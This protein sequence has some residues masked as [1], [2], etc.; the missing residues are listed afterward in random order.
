MGSSISKEEAKSVVPNES[1]KS[2]RNVLENLAKDIKRKASNNAKRHENVLKANLRQA[3]FRHEFSAYRPNYGNPCELDYRFHTNV[4]NRGASE[5]DPCY[6]R[7]PKNNSK[8]KGAVCTN[9]KIK[10]N[11][12][13]INDTG[14]CAPYRRRNI[15]DY[16]LEHIH[17]GN[18]LT[19][20]DLLGNVLVMAKNEGASI[21]NSNAHN[22]VLNV[23]TVLAR[24][25]ADIGD[26]LRGKDLYLG[27]NESEK[28][29]KEELQGN[30]EK[31]FTKI[32]KNDK[33]LN[34]LSNG[35]VREAWWALNR[36]DVW[37]AL[38]CSAPHNAQYVKYVPG[39]TTAVSSNKCGHNDMNVPTNLDYVPQF[40]R[41]FEEWAEEF[42]RI[43]KIKL[44]NVEKACRDDSKNLYCS[45]NGYDCTKTI[46]NENIL[47]DDPKCNSCLA[48]CSLYDI[49]LRNQRNEFEKQKEIYTKEIQIYLSNK[50]KSSSSI[51]NEYYKDFY[52]ELKKNEYETGNKFLLLLNEGKFCNEKLTGKRS[53]DFSNDVDNIFSH[54]KHCKVCPHCG[55]D[56]SN[57][58]CKDRPNK[59]NCGKN[60]IYDPPSDVKPTKITV[61]YSSNEKR[62]ITE[63]LKDFCTK[64]NKENE[65][66]YQKWQCYYVSSENNGCK[67]VKNSGNITDEEKITSFDEFFDFWVRKFLID[68]IKWENE[69]KTC[70][71]NTTN[72]D[73]NNECNKN[74]ICFYNWVKQKEQE[75]T[76]M[77]DLFTNKHDIPKQYYLNINYLFDSFYFQ[78]MYEL[79]NEEAKWKE[80]IQNLR[81]K[82]NSSKENKGTTDSESA[83]KVLFDHLKETATICK[84]NNTNEA[85]DSNMDHEI[86]PCAKNTTT[87]SGGGGK[88]V[89]VKQIAQYYKRKAHAQLEERGSRS[90]LKGDASQGHYA[91]GG[92]REH[93]KDICKIT[94]IHSNADG[95]KS[96]NPC[97]GKNT[98]RFYTGKDWTYANEKNTTTYSDVYLPQRREHMCTSNLEHLDIRSKGLSNSS[99]ASNS[100]LGDVLLAA[101]FEAENIKKLYQQNNSKNGVIDQ[102]DKETVCRAMKYSFAD[103]GDIIR[104]KDM[105]DKDKGS[106]D[107]E[108]RLVP[109]FKKIKEQLLNSSIKEKYNKDSDNDGNKYINLRKDWWEANRD[110]VWKAMKCPNN[111]ITCGSSDH[112]PLDDYIPQR[113]RWMTEWAEWYCKMQSQEYDKLKQDCQGC[114]GNGKSLPC[115]QGTVQCTK[116]KAACDAYK[117]EIEKWEKQWKEM[118]NK[119]ANLYKEATEGGTASDRKDKDV[120]D[121]LKQLKEAN[122]ASGNTTYSTAAGYIHQE[123]K[124]IDC[125]IQT[126][127]C[128]KRNGD[129]P[130]NGEEKVDNEKY[131]FE[132]LPSEYQ[133]ACN[134]NENVTPRPPA[135]SNV[136]NTVK[137]HIGNN[138]GTQEIDNCK[139]KKDYPPWKNDKSLVDEDGV[140]MPP[141]RQ[142]LCVIN[143]QHFKENTSDGLRKAFI[144]C[145]AA[146]TFLL[147]HKYKKDKND[148]SNN[149]DNTLKSGTIPEEFK[150]QMFYTF[151]DFR[152]L[153]LGTD[154]SASNEPVKTVKDKIKN[155]FNTN[156]G[157]VKG[158]DKE[159]RESFW[160]EHKED[161]WEGMLCALSYDT[162]KQTMDKEVHT[163]LNSNYNYHTI[164]KDLED[165]VNRPQFL[166][167]FTEWSDEFCQ[168]YKVEKAKLFD[169]CNKVDCSKE[170]E[171]NRKKKQ[172]CAEECKAY[173]KWL[174][175]WNDK[176]K[177]QSAKF[178]NDKTNNKYKHDLA[179]KEADT[180][181]SARDYLKT[182]LQ[183]L[184]VKNGDCKCM[185]HKS[186]QSP[187]NTDM[188]A[189]LDDEPDEVK[190]RCKC[191]PPPPPKPKPTRE[192]LGRSLG[193][194]SKE[195]EEEEEEEDSEDDEPGEDTNGATEAPV[196]TKKDVDVCNTV[197]SALDDMGSLTQACQ[198]KYEKGREKFPNW[199]CVTPS[200]DKTATGSSGAI[201]VP[202]RRRKLYVGELTKWAEEATKS[203]SQNGESSGE[204][205]TQGSSNTTVNVDVDLVKAFVESAAVE[206][207]FLWH[208]YKVENTKTQGVG[209]PLLQTI[210]G[211]SGDDN[212]P[213]SK[214]EKGEI[215]P[216]FLRLMFYTLGDYR[217]ICIGGDRDIVG[218]TIVSNTSNNEAS[219]GQV[220]RKTI[221]DVIKQTLEKSGSK[222]GNSSPPIVKTPSQ[223]GDKRKKWWDQNA[224]HIWNGMICALT[225][226][227]NGEKKI[228]KDNEVYKKLWDEANKKPQKHQY[229]YK[230]V[231]LEEN[232]GAKSTG[233]STQ[234]SASSGD[235]PTLNTPKL[236][237]FVLR[238]PYFRYLE[239][240]GET[241][242]RER[243]KRLAQIYK[244]CRGKNA[245]GDPTY[246]SGDGYHCTEDAKYRN[247]KFVDLNCRGCGEQCMK[248]KKWIDMKFKEYQNQKSKYQEELQKLLKDNSNGGGDNKEFCQQIKEKSTSAK[249]LKELKHCK[250]DQGGEE[251]GNELDF[252]HPEKTFSPSTYC[253][254]CPVYGVTCNS[255]SGC[256]EN[257]EK[258]Q[259]NGKRVSTDI[260]IL[261][262]DGA[263]DG[264]TDG[265]TKDIDEKLK[266]C[267]KKYS[268]FKG[269]SKQEWKCQKIN[270]VDQCKLTNHV[271][272]TYFDKDIVFNEF[273]QRWLRYFIYDYNKLKHKIHPCIKKEKQDKTEHKC[274]K[275]CNNKCDCVDK[276]LKQKKQE[277]ENVKSHYNKYPR[278]NDDSVG[279][280]VKSYFDLL[281]FDS[282]IKKIKGKHE[283]FNRFEDSK[284]CNDTENSKSGK[285]NDVIECL[286]ENLGKKISECTSQASGSE[287]CTQ[288]T[289]DPPTLEDEDLLLE[290]EENQVK[291][292]EI[293]ENVLKT[294]QPE[295]GEKGDCGETDEKK[296]PKAEGE[297][298]GA[299]GPSG[300]A[301]PEPP[302]D[303]PPPSTPR[304]QPLP[305]DNTSDILKTTIPFG[306]ALA[307]TSIALLFLKKKP[308][309][310]VDLIRVLDIH[311]GDYGTPTPKSKNRY[312]PYRSGTYKGKTYIYMEGDSS[313]DE[314]YA[315]LS[316]TTDVT[317]SESEYE[318]LDINDIY[319]P[320]APKYKTLIEVV[321]EPSKSDGTP[322]SKGEP[323]RDDTPRATTPL[324]D[325]EWNELKHDFISQYIQSES[326][327]VPQYDVLKELPMN[328]GGNVLDDGINEKPFITSIHDRDLYTGEEISYNINMS[329]NSMDDPKHVSNNVYSGIDLINDTLSGNKNIDI[330][331]EVLKRKENELFGTNYKKNTS[332]NSVAKNTN[333]DPIMNQLDLLHKWLD[334]HRDMCKKWN[335]KEELLDKLNEQW[336]KDNDVGGDIST[337]N[338]NKTLNTDVSIQIDIDETKGKKE[339]SNMNT[340][341]DDIEDDIYYDVNDENP[342]VNDIPMDHNRVDVPKKVHVEM[343]ILNNTSNGSLEQEFPISDVW[344]I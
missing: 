41:W 48:K 257:K 277:W 272:A 337:S 250:N 226:K 49:W 215:P 342:S 210:D 245:N 117:K 332:N 88:H 199:K 107:M 278:T 33:T 85:C 177:I 164:K 167:W 216:D 144:Q 243:A 104:G 318:E 55:V 158:S 61:L 71:N 194:R 313:G 127:F 309:S 29:K 221:S 22:G 197:K 264:S 124:Y 205:Q 46:R 106:T 304:P 152:D 113:L 273:F 292:P 8:L 65:K 265:T 21:V 217:D 66:N 201:C 125:K 178:D 300:R 11:E 239:E 38:T 130:T 319:A 204:A 155:V 327:D 295:T 185:E 241:F 315:F 297:E 181:S 59:G 248:Y 84:D 255:S 331:D 120:V 24:S 159:K 133:E 132:K 163:K 312:I 44:E 37:K 307:L 141:R 5:R 310:P 172:A 291:P 86:N 196:E 214:L 252:E 259:K 231:K 58:T 269:L 95:S 131:A 122:K 91:R 143:L 325:E 192:G 119:Y 206:T 81:T 224:K 25:F 274:I 142:K 343:K 227:D 333:S 322:L 137:E 157:L 115:E 207:F 70:I 10:G 16:N 153:C 232:S 32:I 222:P 299:A 287:Q 341:L 193:P 261:I 138:N 168:K 30:L 136:C 238:P 77:M 288:T 184:C 180:A 42:C 335:T 57:G 233:S 170:D 258:V 52:E 19:T 12:N 186:K 116:C 235:T 293:C 96:K 118:E 62:G 39:N 336:N 171:D 47:S 135:L 317:S 40:L 280:R 18:V 237:D 80:Y 220:T 87:T 266:E 53:I 219:S 34:N 160:N 23:C 209:S 101:K 128:K 67:M 114:V 289:T 165:F 149:L 45:H 28:K 93:F 275:E 102:N 15:C 326:L 242:C 148:N 208:K 147:W 43:R 330:Y 64:S 176:Y 36:K 212:N 166:R 251:K 112:T 268:L 188:P 82:I 263:T 90:A 254:A 253:K 249:F 14:A 60:L 3:K 311:K 260:P 229:E 51:N 213:Q 27:N 146:E 276:W 305:S 314:K 329:T 50:K 98:E 298:S 200:G 94:Q 26:I 340:I 72:A 267:S 156:N 190:G 139:P 7:Q 306:I 129:K 262:N 4:W 247:H 110:Q 279:Y 20:D 154:I 271:D 35:Q 173:Q 286:L 328:I 54:S 31:I 283:N 74:C 92:S 218:D 339:F 301:S 290:E 100:L 281:Y 13:K 145:A 234:S 1:P 211:N 294:P 303:S 103:I 78:V 134:C 284:E 69:V 191:P 244:D 2:P 321:L 111:G 323:L 68:T 150:R 126:Q 63:K 108:N 344:N 308:K 256:K 17:E 179:A 324:T 338:G 182:Q 183:K 6:R 202:P 56:C 123:A 316:D 169:K 236:I 195:K 189:S 302:A 83:I 198:Q 9:S 225:Y 76:N 320:R 73:C 97:H 270:G 151:G 240:W 175:D 246:C 75:W 161:I 99:I 89:S 282:D 230:N 174:K 187:N 105:W 109:I 285:N 162:K 121:F 203:Q 296:K 140:Y 79:N 223:P 228:V 334:R